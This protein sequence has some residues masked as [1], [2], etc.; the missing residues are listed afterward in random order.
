MNSLKL[1]TI[2]NTREI[3]LPSFPYIPDSIPPFTTLHK[4]VSESKTVGFDMLT[5]KTK[6]K[7]QYDS[8]EIYLINRPSQFVF[9]IEYLRKHLS[10]EVLLKV[11]ECQY[12][13][14]LV[15]R[16]SK[17]FLSKRSL[18]RFREHFSILT[19]SSERKCDNVSVLML[20]WLL[21]NNCEY[22]CS[23]NSA[24]T[25]SEVGHWDNGP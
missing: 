12:Y 16:Y 3:Q 9:V 13:P 7:F 23:M 25:Y 2:I 4:Q 21:S 20:C 10:T 15:F 14:F 18:M 6:L 11:S 24:T 8:I 1:D 22:S 5:I 17:L 19:N